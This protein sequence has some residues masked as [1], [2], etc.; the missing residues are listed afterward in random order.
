[1][2]TNFALVDKNNIVVTVI[3]VPV[4]ALQDE[5]GNEIEELGAL[6]CSQFQEGNWLRVY[7]N[8]IPRKNKAGIGYIY[9]PQRDAF[10]SPQPKPNYLFDEA[11]CRWYLPEETEEN[12]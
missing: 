10:I 12:E 3:V 8:G 6:Y 9:D 5:E 2:I 1:M 7:E 11:T 4:E